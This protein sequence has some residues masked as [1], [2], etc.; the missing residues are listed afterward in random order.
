MDEAQKSFN[1][2]DKEI[3]K[4]FFEAID[5]LVEQPKKG[6]ALNLNLEKDE[7]K[8]KEYIIKKYQEQSKN[9]TTDEYKKTSPAQKP[10]RIDK[11]N[12]PSISN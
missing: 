8:F 9:Y 2:D 7:N 5:M 11:F 3:E 1:V 12:R 6:S 4:L 10:E